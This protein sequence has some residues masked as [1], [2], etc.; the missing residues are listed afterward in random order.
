MQF[1]ATSTYP[2][3]SNDTSSAPATIAP[4]MGV[5]NARNARVDKKTQTEN[6]RQQRHGLIDRCVFVLK[7]P[8]ESPHNERGEP[9]ENAKHRN[10]HSHK[11]GKTRD[12]LNS[13]KNTGRNHLSMEFRARQLQYVRTKGSKPQTF[14]RVSVEKSGYSMNP[15]ALSTAENKIENAVCVSVNVIG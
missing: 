11:R 14:L 4:V 10:V 15:N 3:R 2:T 9:T 5:R 13:K 8:L 12:D 6:H 1:K 7:H